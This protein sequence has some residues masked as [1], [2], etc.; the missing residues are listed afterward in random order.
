VIAAQVDDSWKRLALLVGGEEFAADTRLH[1]S[2]GRNAHRAE[3]LPVVRAWV[4]QR[5]V[6]Q[7]LTE[8]E[9]VDVACAKVQRID[10]VLADPQIIER[11]MLIEQDHPL[12]G[13]VQLPNLPFRRSG[14][15]T[16]ITQPAP[17]LGQHNRDIA[18]SLGYSPAEID[19]LIADEVL[20][21][22]PAAAR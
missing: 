8:L 16:S 7:C 6:A 13:R 17:L 22:E 9:A 14:C 21:A 20:Y 4:A 11:G 15:D 2:V 19:E 12:L 10:E 1:H 18:T 5:T 3:I